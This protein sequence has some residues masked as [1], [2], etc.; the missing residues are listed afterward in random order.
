MF[1]KRGGGPVTGMQADERLPA[2]DRFDADRVAVFRDYEARL[3]AQDSPLVADAG[4]WA[5]CQRYA[6]LVV[7][8]CARSLR[9]GEVGVGT[10]YLPRATGLG[11][12]SAAA[13]VELRD[14]VRAV[15]ELH[16]PVAGAL[17][18]AVAGGAG[19][20]GGAGSAG[21]A[22]PDPLAGGPVRP[23]DPA[24]TAAHRAALD[25]L[26]GTIS[27]FV[28]AVWSWHDL[29]PRGPATLAQLGNRQWL[30]REVHDWI[31]NY[32]SLAVR[33]LDLYGV[34]RDRDP[35]AAAA[36]IAELRRTLDELLTGTRQLVSDLRPRR[37]G[38]GIGEALREYVRAVDCADTA[39][40]IAVRGDEALVPAEHRD[41]L[42]A[43]VR[44]AVR[45]A[46]AHARAGAVHAEVDIT[47]AE[48]RM[49]VADDG[50][51]FDPD[52]A[53]SAVSGGGLA[54]MQERVRLLGG[55]LLVTSQPSSGTQIQVWIPLR[56]RHVDVS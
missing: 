33:Q 40:D 25:T 37:T 46:L 21:G 22:G 39:V 3:R 12:A 34:H 26:S 2:A 49:R 16:Q 9:T 54:F 8:A 27:A 55:D 51:G 56:E 17:A 32:V 4:V 38:S 53:P 35:A 15:V 1:D 10:S 28:R 48:V 43:V 29:A 52:A 14:T 11:V 50:V 31:G 36:R 24:V 13:G 20:A 44:E 18:D 23:G 41:E 42:L 47:A 19:R 45:N 30:A 7:S 6:E 5:E